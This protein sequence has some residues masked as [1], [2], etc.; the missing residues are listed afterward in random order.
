MT[1]RGE[2]EAR[3][4]KK[5]DTQR[6]KVRQ[7]PPPSPTAF[8]QCAGDGGRARTEQRKRDRA[9]LSGS[10][11]GKYVSLY[12]VRGH[13]KRYYYLPE[14]LFSHLFVHTCIGAAR[15]HEFNL[16]SNI[17]GSDM[18]SLYN[19]HIVD[20]PDIGPAMLKHDVHVHLFD[21]GDSRRSVEHE[22]GVRRPGPCQ[23]LN[24]RIGP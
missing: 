12:L 20:L 22:P 1:E 7:T 16:H 11:G 8:V 14:R 10:S 13:E 15:I 4:E 3:G 6:R 18:G 21:V 24:I 19:S 23:P 9:G 2:L 5:Q 17:I